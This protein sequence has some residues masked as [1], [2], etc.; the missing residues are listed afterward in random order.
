MYLVSEVLSR[1]YK[2]DSETSETEQ[3]LYGMIEKANE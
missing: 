2:R 3:K 1:Y